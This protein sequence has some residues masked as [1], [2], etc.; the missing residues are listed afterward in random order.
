[1]MAV[2]LQ[3]WTSAVLLLWRCCWVLSSLPSSASSASL[4]HSNDVT[5]LSQASRRLAL[6][7][8]TPFHRRTARRRHHGLHRWQRSLSSPATGSSALWRDVATSRRL[9]S[10]SLGAAS[11]R[12]ETE[13]QPA[14]STESSTEPPPDSSPPQQEDDGSPA[15]ETNMNWQLRFAEQELKCTLREMNQK[16]VFQARLCPRPICDEVVSYARELTSVRSLQGGWKEGRGGAGAGEATEMTIDSMSQR[17]A[18]LEGTW[19]VAFTE[20]VRYNVFP[21]GLDAFLVFDHDGRYENYVTARNFTWRLQYGGDYQLVSE[22]ALLL[23]KN[24]LKVNFFGLSIPTLPSVGEEK[25]SMDYFDG[26][27]WI[28]KLPPQPDSDPDVAFNIYQRVRTKSDGERRPEGVRETDES[29][30]AGGGGETSR[31]PYFP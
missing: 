4:A 28:E 29:G 24:N 5:H 21:Q 14:P 8:P 19:R 23:R 6:I 25:L 3:L 27:L 18:L 30:G 7:S 10:V 26:D 22:Q 9:P 12:V 13:P 17:R 11:G 2:A 20:E 15:S 31:A 1:M 16:E